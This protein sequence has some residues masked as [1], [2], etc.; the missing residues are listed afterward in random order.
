MR[1]AGTPDT[2]RHIRRRNPM[3]AQKPEECDALF[4]KCVNEGNLE[5]LV[6]L[7]EPDATLIPAPG[8]VAVGT[9]AIRA[10]LKPMFDAGFKVKMDLTQTLVSGEV[11]ACY[12]DWTGTAKGPDGNE[13]P[14]SGKA[15][16][17]CHRQPDG[18]WKFAID[19]PYA[20]G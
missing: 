4:E 7:Y 9:D 19:D 15:I 5:A 17:I 6:D 12:N 18:T 20:R 10:A 13:M 2:D 16:E 11:A 1:P 14:F 8:Q 3:P